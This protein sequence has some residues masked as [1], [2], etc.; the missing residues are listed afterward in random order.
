MSLSDKIYNLLSDD[1]ETFMKAFNRYHPEG[2]ALVVNIEDV[3]EAVKKIIEV[4]ESRIDHW[5]PYRPI[6][7]SKEA[8]SVRDELNGILMTIE[9]Q[10]GEK[11]I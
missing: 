9:K 11:L 8:E 6:T 1:K 5:T 2:K 4:I 3:R 7:D 10:I